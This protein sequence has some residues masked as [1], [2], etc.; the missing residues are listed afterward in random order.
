MS[1]LSQ[2][3]E[4]TYCSRC[5]D[6]K[7]KLGEDRVR[8]I[9]SNPQFLVSRKDWSL[10]GGDALGRSTRPP[11][12]YR[13]AAMREPALMVK[14]SRRHSSAGSWRRQANRS[15]SN[16]KVVI[17]IHSGT[18]DECENGTVDCPSSLSFLLP[19]SSSPTRFITHVIV[20]RECEM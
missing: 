4:I 1:P 10:V 2:D 18:H 15:F 14:H 20:I 16:S 3:V 6:S 11:L 7:S 13:R 5:T 19:R 12:T 9:A 8:G 17:A